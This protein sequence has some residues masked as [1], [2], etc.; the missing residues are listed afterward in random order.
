MLGS[1]YC[2][3]PVSDIKSLM[4]W[5]AFFALIRFKCSTLT[6]RM[7]SPDGVAVSTLDYHAE[8]WDIDSRWTRFLRIALESYF[9]SKSV[10]FSKILLLELGLGQ[11]CQ[12]ERE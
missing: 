7:R 6:H 5:I 2:T 4:D 11:R 10:F 12:P 1:A 8:G 9:A 3:V